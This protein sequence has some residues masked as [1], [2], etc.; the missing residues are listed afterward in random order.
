MALWLRAHTPR[1]G[2]LSLVPST[3][4]GQLTTASHSSPSRLDVLVW[5]LRTSAL[6]HSQTQTQK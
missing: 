2:D 5:I 6:T 4:I 1:V 3:H